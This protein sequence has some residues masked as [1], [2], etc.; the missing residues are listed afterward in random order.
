MLKQ[1][2]INRIQRLQKVMETHSL[3]SY[4][5]TAEEDIWYLTNITYKP[6]ERPF[7]IVISP[8]QKPILVVPKL[9]E[10]HVYKGI[11]E[12]RS[13]HIGNIHLPRMEI[14]MMF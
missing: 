6:E 10:A 14:G 4:I 9:E 8:N 7:F 2:L 12:C 13:L 5:I 3:D 1:E 11:V